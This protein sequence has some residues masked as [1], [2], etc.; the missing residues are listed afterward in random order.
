MNGSGMNA[1]TSGRVADTKP[2]ACSLTASSLGVRSDEW[3]AL[4]AAPLARR[5]RTERGVRITV[6]ATASGEL[7]RL[8]DLERDCC[9]WMEFHFDSPETVVITAPAAGVDVL[10]AMFLDRPSST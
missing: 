6:P 2:I 8:I 4:L 1:Q 10:F 7:R 9:A 5:E 3:Q